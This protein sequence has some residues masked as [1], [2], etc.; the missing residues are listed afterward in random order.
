MEH[1]DKQIK[2]LETYLESTLEIE[3]IKLPEKT[4]LDE[5]YNNM[6]L[7]NIE[8]INDFLDFVGTGISIEKKFTSISRS[9]INGLLSALHRKKQVLLKEKDNDK[10]ME[11]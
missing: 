10:E 11:Q 3:N 9:Q 6:K 1:I 8:Q 5:M 7:Y 4:L 2:N